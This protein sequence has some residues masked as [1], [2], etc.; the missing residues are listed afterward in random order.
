MPTL[1]ALINSPYK[2]SVVI[3]NPDKPVGKHQILTPP[4]TKVVAERHG[5]E[6][7]QP[8]K[9]RDPVLIEQFREFQPEMIIVAAYGK[10]IPKE[11]IELPAKGI[12]NVHASLLPKLRGASPIQ[13]AILEGHPE[14][15]VTI[16]QIDEELDHGPILAERSIPIA[17]RET[18]ETLHEKL[19][20]LG[21][22]LLLET[23]PK[24]LSGEIAPKEQDHSQA[25]FTKILKK[26][27]GRIDW[28]TS[29]VHIE[30]QIRAFH[31]WPGSWTVWNKKTL[32]LLFV[33]LLDSP[34]IRAGSLE[35][36][37]SSLSRTIAGQVMT[38]DRR[39]F[40][41]TGDDALE[42]LQLQLE[43]KPVMDA[44]SFL[45]GHPEIQG[46]KLG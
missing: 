13:F 16:M 46:A 36:Y 14:T 1:E 44:K 38:K 41:G 12:L 22:A 23:L 42:I 31:P 3:S 18:F 28:A 30:R 25:T 2:P 24:W 26:E 27:D 19:S 40:I 43:G 11:I 32:K 5:I 6:V 29:A 21:A 9:L 33:R 39:L 7:W 4:P 10:I 35:E 20:K 34:S 15:G 37:G 17:F 45:N 8:P